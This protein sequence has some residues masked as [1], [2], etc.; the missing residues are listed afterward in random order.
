MTHALLYGAGVCAVLKQLRSVGMSKGIVGGLGR[1]EP[2]VRFIREEL[3]DAADA[4]DLGGGRA[5]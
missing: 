4:A 1:I 5:T 3:V 2:H